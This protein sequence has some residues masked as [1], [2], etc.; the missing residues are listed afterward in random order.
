M[1]VHWVLWPLMGMLGNLMLP[2]GDCQ[3][4]EVM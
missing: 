4:L 2:R 1:R 3:V